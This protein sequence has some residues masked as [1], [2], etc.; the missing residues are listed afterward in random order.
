MK[1][2]K[3]LA[4]LVIL[5]V[6]ALAI[7]RHCYVPVRC[8]I[9]A[10]EVERRTSRLSK[11]ASYDI[12]A[13]TREN[14]IRLQPCIDAVPWNVVYRDL[15]AANY[16]LREDHASMRAQYEAALRYDRRPELHFRLGLALLALGE[17]EAADKHL[18]TG[19]VVWPDSLTR[20]QQPQQDEML[21]RVY[22]ARQG[23]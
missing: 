19:G 8:T 5:T 21:Q 1:I 20:L 4:A 10:A 12:A 14:L 2:V 6:A 7:R 22:K 13:G 16:Q 3:V 17:T 18:Y 11:G 23:Y 15:A 9:I